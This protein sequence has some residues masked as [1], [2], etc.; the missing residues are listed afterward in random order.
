MGFVQPKKI[1]SWRPCCYVTILQFYHIACWWRN[2]PD[3]H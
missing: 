3:L 2:R 1:F